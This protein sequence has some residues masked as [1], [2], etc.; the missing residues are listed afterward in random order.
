MIGR[1]TKDSILHI[2]GLKLKVNIGVT[3]KERVKSQTISL[4][5]IITFAKVPKIALTDDIADGICYEKVIQSIRKHLRNKRFKLIEHL[6]LELYNLLKVSISNDKVRVV[7]TKAPK[8]Q[9]FNGEV[10]FEYGDKAN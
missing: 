4:D 3:D 9:G 2:K 5:I 10:S 6:A 1:N 7:I 8:I